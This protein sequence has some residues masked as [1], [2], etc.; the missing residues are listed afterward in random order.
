MTQAPIARG[1]SLRLYWRGSAPINGWRR[2]YFAFYYVRPRSLGPARWLA[3]GAGCLLSSESW[4]SARRV[5]D[6]TRAG[7]FWFT[8]NFESQ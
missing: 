7:S 8:R 4:A 3:R 6:A 5:S 1:R 2:Y